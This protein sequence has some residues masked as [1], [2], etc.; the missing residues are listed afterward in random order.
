MSH[1]ESRKGD[2]P[3]F[4]VIAH[5]HELALKGRN[6]PF[7]VD[8]LVRNI[9]ESL[10]GISHC[11]VESLAGRTR[12]SVEEP[13]HWPTIR[14]RLEAVFGLANFAPA[15]LVSSELETMTA[16]ICESVQGFT[17]HTFRVTAKRADK[18]YP[19]TS[20]DVNRH[21]GAAVVERT[22]ARVSL[23]N[24]ELTI[25]IE[26]MGSGAYYY[27][28]RFPGPGGLPVGMSGK[29]ACLLSGGIDSP[30]A[31]WRMMKRGCRAVFVH[32]HGHPY[33]TRASAEKA[34][35]LA[36]RLTRH[37]YHSR[38]CLVP[39]GDIQR[40]IVLAAPAPLR[41][42][43]YRRLMVRI[44]EE[45]GRENKCWALVSG[46]S[47]GQVAS[48]TAGNLTVVG[49]AATI[50]FLRP[51]IGMDKVEITDQAQK[52]GTYEISIE[53]DQDCCRLFTP[54]NPTTQAN[55]ED[56]RR[57]ESRLDVHGLVKQALEKVELKEF[58]FPE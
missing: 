11:H 25:Y 14:S 39:F 32:F 29:V 46:D 33:V 9:R 57:A 23:D 50:P 49:E 40:Q 58:T 6:R 54:P 3:P 35:E 20:M 30:V 47:L 4:Y 7:L 15:V 10:R 12:I 22:G 27:H 51:L 16:A 13:S 1:P 38:L 44:A 55:L 31:A 19:L 34:E 36:R 53:P 48:Q 8:R 21:V 26:I 52:I 56:I 45:I 18:S 17:F 2:S 28:E 5:Y 24:P 42:V 43:L 41:V 37:Q